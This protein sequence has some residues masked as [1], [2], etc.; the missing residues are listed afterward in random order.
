MGFDKSK[1][2]LIRDQGFIPAV[3]HHSEYVMLTKCV[4]T[5]YRCIELRHN[6]IE[7]GAAINIGVKIKLDTTSIEPSETDR[8]L[9]KLFR[10]YLQALAEQ[11]YKRDYAPL[12]SDSESKALPWIQTL[13][14][15][16][17]KGNSNHPCPALFLWCLFTTYTKKLATGKLK[18]FKFKT[19]YVR[20]KEERADTLPEKMDEQVSRKIRCDIILFDYLLELLPP[21]DKEYAKFQFYALTRYD[22]F[23]HYY[24]RKKDRYDFNCLP[25]LA[26]G[27]DQ[28][29]CLIRYHIEHCLMST[30]AWLS[31]PVPSL[32]SKPL[33]NSLTAL[34]LYD[35]NILPTNNRLTD[36]VRLFLDKQEGKKAVEKYFACS[37]SASITRLVDRLREEYNLHFNSAHVFDGD[38]TMNDPNITACERYVI[39]AVLKGRAFNVYY[40][41]LRSKAEEL[42]PAELFLSKHVFQI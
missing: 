1:I 6:H 4:E 39:E 8:K 20:D 18:E 25:N 11:A 36:R 24:I 13:K 32:S 19:A 40:E 30:P 27:V 26:D 10:V 42:F 41:N 7:R 28:L 38:E 23:T 37:D 12:V 33:L 5:L 35:A 22:R 2:S 14:L 17:E 9:A 29:G 21:D 34:L 3:K 31:L 15:Y 16:L